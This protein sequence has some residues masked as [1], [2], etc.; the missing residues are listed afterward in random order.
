M[1]GRDIGAG[2]KAVM[3]KLSKGN[4]YLSIDTM[5]ESLQ[6]WETKSVTRFANY[7]QL[8]LIDRCHDQADT[9]RALAEDTDETTVGGLI[10]T[11]DW[12]FED[13]HALDTIVCSSVHKAKGLEADRVYVLMESLYRRGTNPEEENIEYVAVTRAKSHLTQ[14]YEVPSLVKREKR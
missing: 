10:Q 3:L 12:L 4:N 5:L 6:A 8:D 7:G 9:I 1:A 14:V 13:D 2:I 11:L